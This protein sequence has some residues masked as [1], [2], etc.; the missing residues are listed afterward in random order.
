ME[1][2]LIKLKKP[3]GKHNLKSLSQCYSSFTADVCLA[4]TTEKKVLKIMQNID[5]SKA[6]GVDK[7][8]T[9]HFCVLNL[10]RNPH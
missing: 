1:S 10:L 3:L 4:S 9:R 2:L 7:L 5:N 8:S 6:A